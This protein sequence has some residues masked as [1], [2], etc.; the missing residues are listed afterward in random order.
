LLFVIDCFQDFT[1]RVSVAEC[2]NLHHLNLKEFTRDLIQ[3]STTGHENF[4]S[5]NEVS[6]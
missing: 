3:W 4:H 2:F 6:I 1:S 5:I